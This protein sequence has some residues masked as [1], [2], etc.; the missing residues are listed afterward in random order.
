MEKKIAITADCV[1][2]LSDD[3]LDN[4]GLK[5]IYFYITTDNGCFKDMDE[6]TAGNVVEYFAR[7]GKFIDT[8]APEV[9]E[10]EGLF[11]KQLRNCDE[12]IHITIT[13]KL[14]KS[15]RR[16]TQAA[17]K[18]AGR[19]HVFD[20]EHLSTGIG[21]LVIK[22]LEMVKEGKDV[23][24][25]LDTLSVLKGKVS[26]SFIADKVDYLYR[27]GRV[28]KA[29][30]LICTAFKI[31]PVLTMKNGYLKIKTVYIGNYEKCVLRYVR[32]ELKKG[33]GIEKKRV[34]ITHASC[35]VKLISK[36]KDVIGKQCPFEDVYVTDAS[37]TITS[38]CGA[39]T[40]GVLFVRE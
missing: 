4:L 12:V 7:G 18:F 24:E 15:Y 31:H 35:T 13:S 10:Y 32:K 30:M 8:D 37:A 27:N 6:I 17:E 16:A 20:T 21:H 33:S 2:D 14:S 23:P 38:N 39:N 29:V 28:S 25:I 22:A 40:L 26:T 19:V 5:V 11:E 9:E 36:V 3:M 34:F 1:C